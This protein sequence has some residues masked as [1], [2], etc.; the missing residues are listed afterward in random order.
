LGLTPASR[1]RALPL[2]FAKKKERGGIDNYFDDSMP[3][4]PSA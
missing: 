2:P 3:A 4:K 1:A